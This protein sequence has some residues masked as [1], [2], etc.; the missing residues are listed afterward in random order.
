MRMLERPLSH[1]HFDPNAGTVLRPRF[2]P[3]ILRHDTSL[4]LELPEA[5]LSLPR[6][7][8]HMQT[9]G[10]LLCDSTS[11]IAVGVIDESLHG[12][13]GYR[14]S[15]VLEGSGQFFVGEFYRNPAVL[16]PGYAGEGL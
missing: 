4:L 11:A 14:P 8:R 2:G 12:L 6:W 9:F 1:C 13:L 15:N 10:K 5:A 7:V 16:G 3:I